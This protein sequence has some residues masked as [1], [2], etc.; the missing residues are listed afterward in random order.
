MSI[1]SESIDG[2]MLPAHVTPPTPFSQYTGRQG[3]RQSL[4]SAIPQHDP[5]ARPRL[6][7][8]ERVLASDSSGHDCSHREITEGLEFFF[9]TFF[10]FHGTVSTAQSW[11]EGDQLKALRAAFV[12]Q[13]GSKQ[14][15]P[16][17]PGALQHPSLNRKHEAKLPL[18][19]QR[20]VRFVPSPPS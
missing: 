4:P 9:L 17:K 13:N 3:W 15:P 1:C 18:G 6:R 20:D 16:W 11:F 2:L 14:Q 19:R 8:S 12:T 7:N 5:A 10:F